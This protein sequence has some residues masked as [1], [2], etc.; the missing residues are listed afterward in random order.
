MGT[1]PTGKGKMLLRGAV[2]WKAAGSEST[3]QVRQRREV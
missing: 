3:K 1:R 2:P